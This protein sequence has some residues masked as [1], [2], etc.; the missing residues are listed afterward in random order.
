MIRTSLLA[1]TA[2]AA[3]PAAA[4]AQDDG[5]TFGGAKGADLSIE[6]MEPDGG[7]VTIGRA[8]EYPADIARYLLANGAGAANLSPDGKTIAFSWNVTGESEIWVMPATGGQPKQVTFKTGVQAP[9]WTPDGSSL[10]YSADRDGNEQPAYF[11]LTPDGKTETEVLP[12][13]RG[14]FRIFGDFASDGSFIYASTARGA[15]VFDIYRGTTDG[16]SEL[17]VESELGLAAESI[18]PDGKYALVTERVGEDADN[19]YLLDLATKEMTTISKPPVEDRASHT[20]GGF[21]WSQDSG[22]F[23]FS[24]NTG[25]EFGALSRY[26]IA[27]GK[28]ATAF[29]PEADVENIELCGADDAIIA[30][31]ENRDGFDRLFV[32]NNTSGD[33]V[34]VEALP[35]GTY[36]LDCE[37]GD[38]PMLMVRVNGWKTPGEIWMI[39]PLTGA[40]NKVFEAN[41][42]GLDTSR[43]IR[44]K[45]VR[46]EARDGVELQGLLYLPQGADTGENAPPVV[47]SVHGGPSA[48]SQANFDAIAQYHVARGV[49]VFEPNVR[50]STGLGRTYSTLDDRENRLDSVRDLV[51]LK[52]ALAADGLI[53]GDRAAVM[54]GSYGGYAVNA[55]LAEF[56][57]E[58]AAGVSLFGVADWVTALEIASPSL[59]AAD[60]IEYGDITEDKW[61]EYYTVN[62]PIRKANQITVPVLY[63]HGVM[64]PRI[65]IYETEVMVKTLRANGVEAPFI[66]IPDEGHGWRKLSNRLFYFRKQAEFIEEKLG[67]TEAE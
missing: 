63:S 2:F 1:A 51:D 26:N 34:P 48:Q 55:V 28:I 31:T 21:E 19:L 67:V 64:D 35:E 9:I 61:R 37:G 41:L 18:S 40:G 45:V 39:D 66:R 44:P 38:A 62:S 50:G 59:K 65:D 5:E 11:A 29:E 36:S 10:F 20:I 33:E 24:T 27:E 49:A 57:G 7:D 43:L 25:R 54:G 16:K 58:F 52:N 22:T 42:A 46:Y 30:Y 3:I 15:G 32:R 4:L 47:F 23:Y 8:G 12:A 60:K 17:I 53:D 13:A 14:D 56:P 6:A